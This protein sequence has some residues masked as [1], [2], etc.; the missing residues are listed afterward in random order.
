MADFAVSLSLS[1]ASSEMLKQPS[2]PKWVKQG[3]PLMTLS[4][5]E[6]V[7]ALQLVNVISVKPFK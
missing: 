5:L 7:I 6:S 3:K 4:M 2:I 1:T